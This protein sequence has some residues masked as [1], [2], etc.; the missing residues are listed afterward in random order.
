MEHLLFINPWN[1]KYYNNNEVTIVIL[2][3]LYHCIFLLGEGRKVTN[4]LTLTSC[5]LKAR[6][7][8]KCFIHLTSNLHDKPLHFTDMETEAQRT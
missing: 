5:P 8:D 4:K 6:Q 2:Y 3:L 7:Y 1:P